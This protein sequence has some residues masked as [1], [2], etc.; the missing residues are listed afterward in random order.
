MGKV[1]QFKA[2]KREIIENIPQMGFSERMNNI[3]ASIHKINN[4]MIELN[5]EK[6]GKS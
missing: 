6:K 1:I 2:P 5:K 4:L 3:R